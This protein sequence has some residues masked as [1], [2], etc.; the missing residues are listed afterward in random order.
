MRQW[1]ERHDIR[2]TGLDVNRAFLDHARRKAVE[3]GLM[4]RLSFVEGPASAFEAVP[5]SYDVVLC[6]GTS[7]AL[8]GFVAALDWMAGVVRP[9]GSM[10]IGDMTLKHRPAV[11]THEVLPPDALDSIA[12]IE[13]HGAEVS[14]TIS[15]SDAD[16]ERYVSHHRQATLAWGREHPGHAFHAEVLERSRRDWTY[17]LR[18]IR[19]MLGWTIFVGRRLG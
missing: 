12:V 13:R 10:V 4:G 1:A 11:N 17:Y 9:G 14:A 2:G 15:A 18:T 3:R 16:F 8:G 6:L 19:P 5:A 7:F